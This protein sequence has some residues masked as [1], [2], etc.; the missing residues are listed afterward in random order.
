M[1]PKPT[2]R[3]PLTPS[4][5]QPHLDVLLL[6]NRAK[7]ASGRGRSRAPGRKRSRDE[8]PAAADMSH[9]ALAA[10]YT[11]YF[12]L[13]G[14]GLV[15]GTPFGKR[16]PVLSRLPVPPLPE[17]TAGALPWDPA[18]LEWCDRS[19]KTASRLCQRWES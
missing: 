8:S 6:F 12:R 18:E 2:W 4:F 19:Q 17:N 10:H 13:L 5:P 11:R 3:P 1:T 7:H 15:L 14:S 9:G 16:G